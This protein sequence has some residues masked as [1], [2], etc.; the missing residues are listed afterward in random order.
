MCVYIYICIYVY[1]YTYIIYIYIHY[2]YAP[3]L[4]TSSEDLT[5]AD[6]GSIDPIC[7]AGD[8]L[9]SSNLFVDDLCAK[10]I[11]DAHCTA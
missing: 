1:I 6:L 11:D 5:S 8:N 3:Q 4:A 7:C 9:L 2:I 10:R